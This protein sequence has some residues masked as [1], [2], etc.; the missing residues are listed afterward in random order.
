MSRR[1][2]KREW[3]AIAEALAARLAGEIE[4]TEQPAEVYQSAF[5]KVQERRS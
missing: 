4:D 3:A 2:T 5:D 1:L